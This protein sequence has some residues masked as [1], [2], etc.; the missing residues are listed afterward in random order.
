MQAGRRFTPC[1]DQGT[2]DASGPSGPGGHGGC[3]AAVTADTYSNDSSFLLGPLPAS[4]ATVSN[5]EVTTDTAATGTGTYTVDVMDNTGGSSVLSCT[6]NTD[7]SL[8]NKACRN[9]GSAAVTAGRYLQ[10]KITHNGTATNAKWR[11]TFRY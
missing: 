5:L 4:G 11:V 1:A 10:V 6:I 9:T 3:P 7:T 2:T 8:S